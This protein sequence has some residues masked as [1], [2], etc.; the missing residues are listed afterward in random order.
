MKLEELIDDIKSA[1]MFGPCS[2]CITPHPI[3]E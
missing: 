1:K 2:A 3:R